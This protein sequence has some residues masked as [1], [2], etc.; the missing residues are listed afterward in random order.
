M[1][2]TYLPGEAEECVKREKDI[3]SIPANVENMEEFMEHFIKSFDEI[4]RLSESQNKR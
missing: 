1:V 2:Q 3:I 4:N